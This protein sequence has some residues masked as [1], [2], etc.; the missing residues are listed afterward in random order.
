MK[1]FTTL[2]LA[3]GYWNI[4]VV[5]AD[6]EK[7]AFSCSEG[8]FQWRVMPFGLTNAPA[9]FQRA[10]DTILAGMKWRLCLVYLDDVIIFA[11]DVDT[12]LVRLDAVLQGG[13]F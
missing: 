3:A 13:I 4:P 5:E 9:T 10:M 12:H 2:D 1:T 7:T 11:R 8:L 6:K